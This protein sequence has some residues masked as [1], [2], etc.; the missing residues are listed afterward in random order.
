[1]VSLEEGREAAVWEPCFPLLITDM[2]G[3]GRQVTVYVCLLA[4]KYWILAFKRVHTIS[5]A[6]NLITKT[7]PTEVQEREVSYF[8]FPFDIHDF[9][10]SPK[11]QLMICP[12]AGWDGGGAAGV[13]HGEPGWQLNRTN[14]GLSFGLKHGLRCLF[15]SGTCLNYPFFFFS[16]M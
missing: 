7:L 4:A 15:Y 5:P 14:F 8:L 6:I 16:L 11:S 9:S 3:G 1:M 13:R 10:L 12:F 2:A